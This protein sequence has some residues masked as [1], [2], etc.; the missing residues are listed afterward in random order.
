M[1]TIGIK[2]E[3]F[4]IDVVASAI[5]N[6]SEFVRLVVQVGKGMVEGD[7]ALKPTTAIYK[8]IANRQAI[9]VQDK[10]VL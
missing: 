10:I 8:Q 5:E 1:V 7:D 9:N 6:R 2:R 4:F 3:R